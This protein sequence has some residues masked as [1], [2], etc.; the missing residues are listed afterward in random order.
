MALE[1]LGEGVR[2]TAPAQAQRRD[3]EVGEREIEPD[4][5][6]HAEVLQGIELE[7]VAGCVHSHRANRH[8]ELGQRTIGEPTARQRSLLAVLDT[9]AA[10]RDAVGVN[11]VVVPAEPGRREGP[12]T[13]DRCSHG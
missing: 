7:L 1:N 8:Q 11:D 9:A 5:E 13:L 10:E 2:V 12:A 4:S 6:V 3:R